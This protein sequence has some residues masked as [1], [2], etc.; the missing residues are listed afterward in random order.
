MTGR[1]WAS[2]GNSVVASGQPARPR[3]MHLKIREK[4]IALFVLCALLPLCTVAVGSY[5]LTEVLT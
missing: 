5:R 4:S 1:W 3:L 2:V